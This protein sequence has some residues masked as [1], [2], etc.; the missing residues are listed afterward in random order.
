MVATLLCA[1]DYLGRGL[2]A[3]C[4]LPGGPPQP[5]GS[6]AW[7]LFPQARG[8]FRSLA[9]ALDWPFWYFLGGRQG[10]RLEDSVH[11]SDAALCC[12]VTA[13]VHLAFGVIASTAIA[14]VLAW[15][16]E[17]GVGSP[18]RPRLLPRWGVASLLPR[19]AVVGPVLAAVVG[20][21]YASTMAWAVLR[22]LTI[23]LL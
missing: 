17:Q 5:P 23:R 22:V 9:S 11:V 14:Y 19:V 2:P 12:A 10:R 1:A 18:R 20:G 21:V 15:D 8:S 6:E 16:K 7:L 3:Q 13:W 4:A